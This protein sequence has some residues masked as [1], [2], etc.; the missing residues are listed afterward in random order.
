MVFIHLN[1]LFIQVFSESTN[2]S[3]ILVVIVPV[4]HELFNSFLV[5]LEIS[6]ISAASLEGVPYLVDI[7][8][9]DVSG[10]IEDFALNELEE[11]Y[12]EVST[13]LRKHFLRGDEASGDPFGWALQDEVECVTELMGGLMESE[14]TF[15]RLFDDMGLEVISALVAP[16]QD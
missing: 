9:W 8:G 11:S 10:N 4:L 1:Q 5:F 14:R 6:S 13:L 12:E 15:F 2:D 3:P 7:V 16:L